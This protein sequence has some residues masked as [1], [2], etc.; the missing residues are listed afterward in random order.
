MYGDQVWSAE[1]IQEMLN[2]E[3]SK[4]LPTSA[5]TP[6]PD[7]DAKSEST[8]SETLRTPKKLL[9]R[10]GHAKT[11]VWRKGDT[12][13]VKVQ[14]K[15]AGNE[16]DQMSTIVGISQSISETEKA[17]ETWPSPKPGRKD[18]Y[19]GYSLQQKKAILSELK[20]RINT[21]ETN[22]LSAKT[23]LEKIIRFL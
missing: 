13:D 10:K 3:P 9:Q 5:A 7:F 21:I 1:T 6:N 19:C 8:A 12:E 4:A 18:V 11:R 15:P 23:A 20:G 22:I 17:M 14:V 2:P 16:C